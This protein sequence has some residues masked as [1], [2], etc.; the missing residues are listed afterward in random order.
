LLILWTK[1]LKVWLG[2]GAFPDSWAVPE[3]GFDEAGRI[4][5]VGADNVAREEPMVLAGAE[6]A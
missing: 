1:L 4:S 3:L 6:D 5:E 2:P